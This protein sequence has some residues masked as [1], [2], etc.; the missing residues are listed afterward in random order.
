MMNDQ[1]VEATAVCSV[2]KYGLC[3]LLLE[4]CIAEYTEWSSIS[5]FHLC[6]NFIL[7]VFSLKITDI[8]SIVIIMEEWL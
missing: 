3:W 5:L 4:T 8:V 6:I 2:C 1:C 7:D